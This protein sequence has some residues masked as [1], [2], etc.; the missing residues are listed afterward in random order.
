[1]VNS[2]VRESAY[3]Q[4][5]RN[6]GELETGYVFD[7]QFN[8]IVNYINNKIVPTITN[9]SQNKIHGV[10][11][12]D[13]YLL[14][15]IGDGSTLFNRLIADDIFNISLDKLKRIIPNSVVYCSNDG[16]VPL[17]CD[18]FNITLNS[19]AGEAE[20][21]AI[22]ALN[23]ED[24]TITN[25]KVALNTLSFNH[26][27]D[28]AIAQGFVNGV[29]TVKIKDE[30]LTADKIAD[31][32]YSYSKISDEL[33]AI[34][35]DTALTLVRANVTMLVADTHIIKT[36]HIQN[37]SINFSYMF[38][39]NPVLTNANILPNSVNLVVTEDISPYFFFSSVNPLNLVNIAANSFTPRNNSLVADGISKAKLSPA[40]INKLKIGGLVV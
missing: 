39:N 29:P 23:I 10:I 9:L 32:A 38:G 33:Y 19:L 7:N 24:I 11:N 36:S 25:D 28:E 18:D 15:N 17:H 4:T 40:I 34:R 6:R 5:V 14:R 30:A 22:S 12:S 2:Y 37:N 21:S 26:L 13:G 20:F 31:I 3:F 27:T 1:M 16:L 35:N 8:N